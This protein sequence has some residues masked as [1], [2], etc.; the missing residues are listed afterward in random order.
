MYI[1]LLI[2]HKLFTT[3]GDSWAK[4]KK[5]LSWKIPFTFELVYSHLETLT[6]VIERQDGAQCKPVTL[7]GEFQSKQTSR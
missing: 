3:A 6:A 2:Q 5:K 7:T 4:T 1:F